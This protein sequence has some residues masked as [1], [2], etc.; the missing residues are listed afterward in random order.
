MYSVEVAAFVNSTDDS[1]LRNSSSFRPLEKLRRPYSNTV[2]TFLVKRAKYLSP[3]LD[4]WYRAETPQALVLPISAT[5][6]KTIDV[7]ISKDEPVSVLA[8]FEQ[9]ELC[10][11]NGFEQPCTLVPVNH[12]LINF[13]GDLGFNEKQKGVAQRIFRGLTRS[14]LAQTIYS[15]G[16]QGLLASSTIQT[17]LPSPAVVEHQ[18]KLEVRNWFGA[19]LAGLQLLAIQDITGY[20]NSDFDQYITAYPDHDEWMCESQVVHRSDFASFSVLGL[21]IILFVGCFI[22][23]LSEGLHYILPLLRYRNT[24]SLRRFQEWRSFDILEL[25]SALRMGSVH[26]PDEPQSPDSVSHGSKFQTTYVDVSADA[27]G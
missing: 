23:V 16:S 15:L 22:I 10:N 25:A 4:P 8:C 18:W 13:I 27:K 24:A 11:P 21:C 9:V 14:A 19:S 20:G 17:V 2:L 12:H 26:L 3:V 6:S 1:S 5:K 7:F